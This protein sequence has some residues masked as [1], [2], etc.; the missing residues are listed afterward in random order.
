VAVGSI[1][2]LGVVVTGWAE[3]Q[4]PGDAGVIATVASTVPTAPVLTPV[5][6]PPAVGPA[7][8]TI[9]TRS[10]RLEDFP[11]R[12]AAKPVALTIDAIEVTA[13]VVPVG[14]D[15][16]TMA[17]EVPPI[18]SVVAW[19]EHGPSPGQE[20][21]AVI[22]GHVDFNGKHGVFFHLQ[23]VPLGST[24]RVDFD[25]GSSKTFV[26]D[27]LRSYSKDSL[28]TAEMF[29]RQGPPGL[30]LVT[31]G[32]DYNRRTRQYADNIVLFAS[33]AA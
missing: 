8:P 20:G 1:A 27:A 2:S 12:T 28:P 30:V 14:V 7:L 9:A 26:I 18:A 11:V 5:E 13:D 22:A 16:D 10:A 6:V 29:R 24:A 21:S 32:G 33:P 25:D 4:V 19:Y 15:A 23:E 31:C 17:M 3:R